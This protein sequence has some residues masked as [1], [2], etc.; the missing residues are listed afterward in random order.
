MSP[1]RPASEHRRTS[2]LSAVVLS[3]CSAT[4]GQKQTLAPPMT[5]EKISQAENEWAA[6]LLDEAE[7]DLVFVFNIAAGGFGGPTGMPSEEVPGTIERMA[8]A[9]LEGG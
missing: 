8:R 9:L 5:L 2:P 3:A 7:R 6:V 4:V 1:S